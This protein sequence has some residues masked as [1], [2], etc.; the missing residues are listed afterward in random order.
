[1][2]TAVSNFRDQRRE[3]IVSVAREVFFEVGYAGASMSMISARLGGS[4]ATLYAYFNS[5]DELFEA[6]ISERCSGFAA[7]F[8]DHLGADDLRDSLKQIGRK[9]M[10]VVLSDDAIRTM[11]LIVEESHR[12]PHLGKMFS[13]VMQSQGSTG[14]HELLQQAHERGQIAAPNVNEAATV[15]KSLLFGDCHFKRMMNLTPPPDEATVHRQID[16]AIDVFMTYYE[17]D[18]VRKTQAS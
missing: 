5:K 8:D 1:M 4:K 18:T 10:E 12:N 11:Q 16:L 2:D 13:T 7:V 14:L 15:L 6:I 17:Q 3:R 9:L